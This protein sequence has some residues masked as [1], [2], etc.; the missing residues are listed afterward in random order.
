MEVVEQR[1]RILPEG[2]EPPESV[3][4]EIFAA[5]LGGFLD[6]RRLDMRALAGELGISRA[7]LYRR[8][9]GRDHLLSEVIWFLTRHAIMRALAAAGRQRGTRR[10]L[11]VVEH[12]MRDVHSQPALRRFLEQEPEAALRI[13]TSKHAGVQQGIIHAVETILAEEEEGGN[14]SLGI[15]RSTLAYVIVR[16]GESFLYADVIAENEPDV[17]E[18][19]KVIGRLLG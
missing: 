3:P 1:A 15:E 16:V 6:C 18:A 19:V 10:V 12:F 2:L 17:D 14:L 9:S 4:P 7:T 13:L 11:S 5:A 8:V